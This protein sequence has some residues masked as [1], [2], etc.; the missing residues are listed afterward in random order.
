MSLHEIYKQFFCFTSVSG[1]RCFWTPPPPSL[2]SIVVRLAIVAGLLPRLAGRLAWRL[3]DTNTRGIL[4]K[5]ECG[6]LDGVLMGGA[7]RCD[8]KGCAK[9][10]ARVYF[11]CRSHHRQV[12]ARDF[13]M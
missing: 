11:V 8:P 9:G 6:L 3:V 5:S 12:F 1:V 10:A 2:A 4:W 13:A 7:R